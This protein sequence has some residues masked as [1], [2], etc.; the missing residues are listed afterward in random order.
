MALDVVKWA[1][2]RV[3]FYVDRRWSDGKWQMQAGPIRLASYHADILRHLFTPDASGRLPYDVIAWCEPAKGGKSAIAGLAAQYMALHGDKNSAIVMASNNQRQAASLM[4]KSFQDSIRL[5][6]ALDLDSGKLTTCLPTGCEVHAITSNS[7]A[8]AGARFSLAIFD[9]MWG[10]YHQ[11]AERLWGE[12][13]TDPTRRNSIKLSVGYAGYF[14]SKLWL[15]TLQVGLM[16]EP[17]PDLA[18]IVNPDGEPACWRNGRSFTF[19]SHQCR[20]PWQTE[21]WKAGLR[22][23]LR[24]AEYRRMIGCEFVEGIGNF[25]E[26]EAWKALIDPNHKPLAPGSP[27]PVYVGLDLA[28]SPKGD[29][30]ALIG[31]YPHEGKAKL[32]FHKVWKGKERKHKLTLGS[33]VKPYLLEVKSKFRLAAVCY[34]GW[35]A[36]HLADELRAAGINMVEIPQTHSSRG[37]RDTRLY[38]AVANRELVLYDDPDLE[39]AASGANAKELGN[40][41]IFLQKAGRAKIDLLIALSNCASE[42]LDR[43]APMPLSSEQPM[44]PSKWV[45]VGER[46][47][48][49]AIHDERERWQRVPY[50]ERRRPR[51]GNIWRF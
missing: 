9:E 31:V 30:C 48:V 3:G 27:F 34:D 47:P 8:E 16:G 51:T 25:C 38:E 26:P 46:G 29:D 5:N 23:T 17:V 36:Q 43:P 15:E 18:H 49:T 7:R 35:Q 37:P 10:Y 11:D 4:Y 28:L 14:E 13:K 39:A 42:A 32:A 40:G 6:P 20:Q 33:T 1:E 45:G 44:A 21:E 50:S 22:R 19:W 12:F 2:S 41:M 24:P